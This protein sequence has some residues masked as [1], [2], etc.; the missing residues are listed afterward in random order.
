MQSTINNPVNHLYT[1]LTNRPGRV[2]VGIAGPPGSGKSTLA[3][4][5]ANRVNQLHG[6]HT[7]VAL[8][9]DGFHLSKAQLR[10]MPDPDLAFARRGAPWTF[11]A[12]GFVARLHDLR[13][14]DAHVR[15]PDF[16]HEVGDP[17]EDAIAVD[18]AVK[19]VIVEGLYL[20]HD[21]DG[22][23]EALPV[24]D[25]VWY[26]NTP[27]DVAI[28]RLTQRHMRAW[29]FSRAQAEHRIAQSDGLNAELV[30][31]SHVRAHYLVDS[32]PDAS[33]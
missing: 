32:L 19:M 6:S 22:W 17:V 30:R 12:A 10:Q 24:F 7:A 11:D 33:V 9:M 1:L 28:E 20:L 23:Q 26:L 18:R 8:G 21:H 4:Q 27:F 2:M 3:L 29:N 13:R 14:A 16:A 5:L 31:Q 15:W 25:E